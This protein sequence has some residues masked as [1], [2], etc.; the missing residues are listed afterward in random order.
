LENFLYF[1]R[2][3][4]RGITILGVSILA[5]KQEKS[6]VVELGNKV[7]EKASE[8]RNKITEGINIT[9]DHLNFLKYFTELDKKVSDN[10]KEKALKVIVAID[11]I[12]DDNLKAEALKDYIDSDNKNKVTEKI[13]YA[14]K[15]LS[16]GLLVLAVAVL[17]KEKSND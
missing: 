6:K 15:Y 17:L 14:L 5:E 3:I 1:G 10:D 13:I 8:V 9:S 7:G 2:L 12:K 16:G 11:G 4:W